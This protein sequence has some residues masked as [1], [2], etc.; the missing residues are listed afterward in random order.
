MAR[1]RILHQYLCEFDVFETRG[2]IYQSMPFIVYQRL[3][4]LLA[5]PKGK[6]GEEEALPGDNTPLKNLSPPWHFIVE[7]RIQRHRFILRVL[8]GILD[9]IG[10]VEPEYDEVHG[11][12]A[13]L[14]N[15][16]KLGYEALHYAGVPGATIRAS[17]LTTP[18]LPPRFRVKREF[19][20]EGGVLD[21]EG[22]WNFLCS[23]RDQP[24]ELDLNHLTP[25]HIALALAHHSPC[26]TSKGDTLQL[27]KAAFK[28]LVLELHGKSNSKGIRYIPGAAWENDIPDARLLEVFE[29]YGVSERDGGS[30]LG[31]IKGDNVPCIH[32][33]P[34]R[35]AH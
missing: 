18:L 33:S 27:L 31:S 23:L 21:S 25:L 5:I 34:R 24:F 10:A 30:A 4:G 12:D 8:L 26:W 32:P 19:V 17:Y 9:A 1:A 2:T 28:A 16:W 35:N 11:L 7:S 15:S 6:D 14:L 13:A 20:M 29:R 3:V 22:L